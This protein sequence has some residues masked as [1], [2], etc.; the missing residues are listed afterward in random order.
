MDKADEEKERK[1]VWEKR[2]RRKNKGAKEAWRTI[3]GGN[4]PMD[5]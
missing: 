4:G 2:K 1:E 3:L 5:R